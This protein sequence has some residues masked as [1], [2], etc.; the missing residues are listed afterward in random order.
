MTASGAIL[1]AFVSPGLFLGGAAAIAAPVLIHLLAR[2]RFRRIRW[3]AMDFLVDAER[4]N[5]RRVRMEEWILLALRCLAVL[6]IALVISRP[7]IRPGGL[8]STL[9]GSRQTE[10]IFILDDSFSMA[11]VN[12]DHASFELAKGAVRTL[13]DAIRRE[14]PDDTV[15]I[16]RMSDTSSPVESGTYL[17]PAQT[18]A[19]LAR[20]DA[21][22][23]SNR[24]IEVNAVIAGTV[25]YLQRSESI[26]SAAV[27]FIS[28]FQSHNWLA[29]AGTDDGEKSGD[30]SRLFDSLTEWAGDERACRI[31]CINVADPS[32]A[33]TAVTELRLA[34]GRLVA[35]TAGTLRTKVANFSPE[36]VA[37]VELDVALGHWPQPSKAIGDLAAGQQAAVEVA[38]DFVQ[39]G[40]VALTASLPPDALPLDNIRW[41]AAEVSGAVRVLVVNGEPSDDVLEDETAFL[42]TAL[43]PE[44]EVFSGHECE[45]IDEVELDDTD[46]SDYHAVVLA[47]VYRVS[48]PAVERLER[49]AQGGGGL[50]MCLGDQVDPDLYNTALYRDGSG[51]LP[52]SLKEVRRVPDQAH[53]VAVDRLHPTMKGLGGDADPLGVGLIPFFSFFTCDP[54]GASDSDE[55]PDGEAGGIESTAPS[56]AARAARVIA[57]FDDAAQSPAFIERTMGLGRVVLVTTA[58]DKEWSLWPDHPAYLPMVHEL[59]RHVARRGDGGRPQWVAAPIEI[60]IDPAVYE[61]DALV[62]TPAYPAE[63]EIGITAAPSDDG[64]GLAFRWDHTDEPGMYQFVLSRRDGGQRVRLVAVNPDPRESDLATCGRDELR[65]AAGDVP[66]EYVDGT[67]NLADREGASRTELW[68]GFLIFGVLVLM[69]EQ[70]LAWRWGSRR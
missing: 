45:V 41:L 12:G 66:F 59:V 57:A 43:R 60:P 42:T 20:L 23:P 52:A 4:R 13:I 47:N 16:L 68:R 51:C 61:P 64:S 62:R 40:D 44:G 25:D 14:T 48:E 38:I 36:P 2:R 15:T 58:V 33:N 34:G 24:A 49:F 54:F 3:A 22:T 29:A 10:R 31:V 67:E 55:L 65:A 18:E 50:V 9:G 70:G 69:M 32:A 21:L 11:Y 17:D 30:K 37:G 6:L 39:A 8:A 5:R 7:F 26:V 1:A 63:H 46:L 53:L 56:G 35:G 27:Y 19:L 28:D